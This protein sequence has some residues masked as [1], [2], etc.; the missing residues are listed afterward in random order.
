[1]EGNRTT[2]IG[3]KPQT[4]PKDLRVLLKSSISDMDI[5]ELRPSLEERLAT[6]GKVIL[7]GDE[8]SFQ[9]LLTRL[10]E[11]GSEPLPTFEDIDKINE[12]IEVTTQSPFEIKDPT[13]F[14]D[15]IDRDLFLTGSLDDFFRAVIEY[16]LQEEVPIP[17]ER[18]QA[19]IVSR[20]N[21]LVNRYIEHAKRLSIEGKA[22]EAIGYLNSAQKLAEEI[23][24]KIDSQRIEKLRV[25]IYRDG[26]R[27]AIEKS[28]ADLPFVDVVDIEEERIKRSLSQRSSSLKQGLMNAARALEMATREPNPSLET[29]M[30]SIVEVYNWSSVL[31]QK[32]P[33]EQLY[34]VLNALAIRRKRI[35]R[36]LEEMME[37]VYEEKEATAYKTFAIKIGIR[38]STINQMQERGTRRW[39]ESR[40]DH[41][42]SLHQY[43]YVTIRV[44]DLITDAVVVKE[45]I[46]KTGD[47]KMRNEFNR[48]SPGL[49][50]Q[51]FHSTNGRLKS[52]ESEQDLSGIDYCMDLMKQMEV[53]FGIRTPELGRMKVSAYTRL[54]DYALHVAAHYAKFGDEIGRE[55]QMQIVRE[56]SSRLLNI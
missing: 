29:I 1:M 12:P 56:C 9:H 32:V 34:P 39:A 5:A 7:E 14:K 48:I 49:Y 17:R 20:Y 11:I 43:A 36:L 41:L 44:E 25:G 26:I 33:E 3:S 45:C 30:G 46:S 37:V 51:A 21:P 40:L 27:K 2:G 54:K 28:K 10:D 38:A 23:K 42:K 16:S 6:I 55:E 22:D 24:I 8:D 31:N 15:Y 13:P 53:V 4:P 35:E 52:A 18:M 19:C 50:Q 47:R